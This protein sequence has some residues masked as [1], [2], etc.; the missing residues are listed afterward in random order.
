MTREGLAL[1][2][3]LAGGASNNTIGQPGAGNVLS[4]NANDG[5]ENDATGANNT[6]QANTIG[7]GADGSTNVFNGRYGVVLY[8]GAN[9]TM[10]G[11]S[12]AGEGNL[13][14]GNADSGVI[15]DGNSNAATT[16]NTIA[17]NLIGTDI[18]G[19]LVRGNTQEGIEID[20]AHG[21]II[22]GHKAHLQWEINPVVPLEDK[23]FRFINGRSRLT[24]RY[25]V[26]H[27]LVNGN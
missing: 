12:G 22:G 17:G 11:G 13:I 20:G 8:D 6:V 4:G 23:L 7:L 10:I 16:S 15:I 2:V 27:L 21:N 25:R 26:F 1:G 14:S 18:T 19:T 5:F 9:N 24:D 3:V